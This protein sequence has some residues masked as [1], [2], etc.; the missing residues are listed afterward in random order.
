MDSVYS[1][2]NFR[3]GKVV[4]A[5]GLRARGLPKACAF[6]TEQI[7]VKH[8]RDHRR[9]GMMG[10]G[11]DPAR[12]RGALDR[13]RQIFAPRL[14]N[15]TKVWGI[16]RFTKSLRFWH[17]TDFGQAQ[18]RPSTLGRDGRGR[19]LTTEYTEAVEHIT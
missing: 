18:K 17:R 4:R 14:F 11:R 5:L 15:L 7:L 19:I 16:E 1:V 6:G 10:A 8:R 13:P 2:V 9:W 3:G 12:T